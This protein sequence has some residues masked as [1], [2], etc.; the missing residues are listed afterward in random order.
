MNAGGQEL[1][2]GRENFTLSGICCCRMGHDSRPDT[3]FLTNCQWRQGKMSEGERDLR[4]TDKTESLGNRPSPL[5]W[6]KVGRM[7]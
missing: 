6:E 2:R 5:R 4:E 7:R 3:K 1:Q